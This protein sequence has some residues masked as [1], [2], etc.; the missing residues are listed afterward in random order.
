MADI[1]VD[2][3]I[4]IWSYTNPSRISTKALSAIREAEVDFTIY[5]SA[6]SIVEL[7][8]LTERQRIETEVLESVYK[9]LEDPDTSYNLV[10]LSQGIAKEVAEIPR[11][12]IPEMPDR[13]ISAT[14]RFL[15]IPLVTTD[16]KILGSEAVETIW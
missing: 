4:L 1:V 2:T 11:T 15:Q 13:I 5:V 16:L 12:E 6:I 10:E 8:Y 7:I 3:H 14:A 9:T